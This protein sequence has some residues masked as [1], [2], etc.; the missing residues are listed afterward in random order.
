VLIVTGERDQ[1][2]SPEELAALFPNATGQTIAGADHFSLQANMRAMDA[3][4]R[5][6]EV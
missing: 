5:F 2:G 1:V 6:L 3:V 4:F